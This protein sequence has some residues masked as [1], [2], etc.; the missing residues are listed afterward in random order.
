MLEADPHLKRGMAVS[1]GVEKI[2]ILMSYMMNG[3][4]TNK[5]HFDS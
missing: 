4:Q 1:H 3:S 5:T 2:F